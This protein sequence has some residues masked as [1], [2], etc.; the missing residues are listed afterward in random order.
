MR[1]TYETVDEE[2]FMLLVCFCLVDFA[3]FPFTTSSHNNI[4][5]PNPQP[6]PNGTDRTGRT[7]IS[8]PHFPNLLL[9]GPPP[10][11]RSVTSQLSEANL[12][13]LRALVSGYRESAA[14][15]YRSANEL[16]TILLGDTNQ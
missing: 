11:M 2:A 7:P 3:D 9:T 4:P 16:E 10:F 6:I 14:F 8:P 12:S 13:T 1:R 15:L 5:T